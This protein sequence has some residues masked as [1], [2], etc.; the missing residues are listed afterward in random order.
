MDYQEIRVLN[1][2][3]PKNAPRAA[4]RDN[5]LRTETMDAVTTDEEKRRFHLAYNTPSFGWQA[6]KMIFD[7]GLKTLPT[8]PTRTLIWVH[9]ALLVLRFP[10]R[11]RED[12]YLDA[13]KEALVLFDSPKLDTSRR[14]IEAAMIT[15]ELPPS[16]LGRK[17]GVSPLMLQ[18]YD[19]LFFNVYDRRRDFMFL[20]EVVYPLTRL[21]EYLEEYA[22]TGNLGKQLMRIGYNNSEVDR[23][24]HFAGF[25]TD[26]MKDF[27]EQQAQT[28]FKRAVMLQGMLLAENGFLSFTK[29]HPSVVGARSVV[30]SGL[31]GGG[32]QTGNLGAGTFAEDAGLILLGV[33]E[34]SRQKLTLASQW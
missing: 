19:A 31:L 9:R 6:A 27:N 5:I 23:V 34:E 16:S 2:V 18:A 17:L 10:G 25:R 29:Q 22:A 13:V 3:L 30:Q 7:G 28:L 33:K 32:E 26:I 4:N 14:V 20:R 11:F 24:L 1:R 8:F 21:E 12:P 15:H